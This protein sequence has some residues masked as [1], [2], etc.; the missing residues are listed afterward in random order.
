MDDLI[1]TVPLDST[2]YAVQVRSQCTA[3][4][5]ISP[6]TLSQGIHVPSPWKLA[7]G[8]RRLQRRDTYVRVRSSPNTM[9]SRW[10]VLGSLTGENASDSIT[11]LQH[12]EIAHDI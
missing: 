8:E 5:Q 7:C 1:A 11:R 6:L 3:T 12:V 2:C 10:T 4:R 9:L